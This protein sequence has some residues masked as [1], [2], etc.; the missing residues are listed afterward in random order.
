MKDDKS[1]LAKALREATHNDP[2]PKKKT[3]NLAKMIEDDQPFPRPPPPA[4]GAELDAY[5][6]NQRWLDELAAHQ[7]SGPF[8]VMNKPSS[9]PL[10]QFNTSSDPLDQITNKKR[11]RGLGR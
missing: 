2:A 11:D 9:S 3:V 4:L 5:D 8:A 7:P 10:D 1:K 6:F